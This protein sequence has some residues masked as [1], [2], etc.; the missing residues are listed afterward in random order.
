MAQ[1]I[2]NK[3]VTTADFLLLAAGRNEEGPCLRLCNHCWMN[4][5]AGLT[6][7]KKQHFETLTET[8]SKVVGGKQLGQEQA[9]RDCGE[10]GGRLLID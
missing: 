3:S 10:E 8:G 6:K 4:L 2:A 7:K 9:G 5:Q 1:I